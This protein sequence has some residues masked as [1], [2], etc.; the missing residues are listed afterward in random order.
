MLEKI[1]D[2]NY[3]TAPETMNYADLVKVV[4]S[5]CSSSPNLFALRVRLFNEKQKP[6]QSVQDYFTHMSQL[7]GQCAM[8][9]MTPQQ[10]GVLA[11]LRGLESD[12]LREFLMSPSNTL[13]D[14]ETARV[15]AV[16][17]D[18][19]RSAAKEIKS[20][21]EERSK[22]LSMNV[23]GKGYKCTYCGGSHPKGKDR[24]PAK[25]AICNKCKKKGHFA[26]K[27]KIILKCII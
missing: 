11:I 10:Y 2:W 26:K 20:R 4:K 18:Q 21:R 24:C 13:T 3:P 1:I 27:Q 19:S 9:G 7:L 15:I 8:N 14:I 6:G 16:N 22:P 5:H 17:F 25:D 23:V 12:D